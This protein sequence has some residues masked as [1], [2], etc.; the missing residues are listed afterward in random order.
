M[1]KNNKKINCIIRAD[2]DFKIGHGHLKRCFALCE[3]LND[4]CNIFF[5]SKNIPK[6]IKNDL[7]RIN[8]KVI[9]LPSMSQRDECLYI[10][11]RLENFNL[12]IIDG[13]HFNSN[14]EKFFY[15]RKKKVITIDDIFNR[16]FSSHVIINHAPLV[17]KKNYKNLTNSKLFLGLDYKIIQKCFYQKKI[18]D[19]SKYKYNI[20]VCLGSGTS[21]FF[22]KVKLIKF[23]LGLDNLNKIFF[24]ASKKNTF[25]QKLE[26]NENFKKLN[27]YENITSKDIARLMKK[28]RFGICTASNISLESY[29]ANLPMLLTY[30][31]DNHLNVY[32]GLTNSKVA[33]GIGKLSDL[34]LEK[35]NSKISRVQEKD[36]IKFF[37]SISKKTINLS[38]RKKLLNAILS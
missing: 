20:F 25:Y 24:I 7:N 29:T 35:L 11:N 2:G 4:Y 19:R 12:I 14:Y 8:V 9:S 21:N 38:S 17:F 1:S 3:L 15:E 28:S 5:F 33:I 22:L 32:K 6:Y 26:H 16:K 36:Y 23:L 10:Y 18:I 34:N 27:I 31:A 13:Y 37:I 30:N